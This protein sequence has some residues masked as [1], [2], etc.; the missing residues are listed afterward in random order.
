[1]DDTNKRLLN[2]LQ[3]GVPIVLRPWVEVGERLG[4]ISEAE[5]MERVQALK[6]AKIIRQISAIFDTCSIG[7]ESSLV[8]VQ[9]DT[10][11]VNPAQSGMDAAAAIINEHPG[12]SH[13]YQR[14][15]VFNLW[16]TI[17]VSPDSRLGLARTAQVIHETSGARSTRLLPTLHL[18]K[19]GVAFDVEG[20]APADACDDVRFGGQRRSPAVAGPL[21]ELEKRFVREMQRD[22][23]I[24]PEPF[25]AVAARLGIGLEE[26]QRV[27]AAMTE[28]GRL[29]RV[30]AVLQHREVG[31]TA[32]AM[33]VWVARGTDA[34]IL[35]AGEKMA[36]F[37]AV[38]HCYR[39]PTYPDW[40]YNLFTMV[41]GRTPAEC[42]AVL[43]EISRKTGIT[44]YAALYSTK[45]YKKER[46]EYFTD[47]EA[48]WE[49]RHVAAD[50]PKNVVG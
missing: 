27:A 25:A 39:R 8:A 41:H 28:S 4:G 9:H 21:V 12:V 29:R 11:R 17:A 26:L 35:A 32:N 14:N 43:A 24:E 42:D 40:P 5:V 30:S 37:R 23:A 10:A 48:E 33:G 38:T 3:T 34:E 18:F 15:H 13:N 6:T 46:I 44:E 31:F 7:Y 45:E 20:G 22:L 50:T 16:Y 47:A 36:G 1:M 49:A 2:L 19:I